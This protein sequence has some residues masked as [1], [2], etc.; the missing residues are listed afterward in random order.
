MSIRLKIILG[1]LVILLISCKD[2]V[3]QETVKIGIIAPLSDWGAYWGIPFINGAEIAKEDVNNN[4]VKLEIIPEDSKGNGK[5]A[6]TAVQ[7]LIN[8]DEITAAIVEFA[9][10]TLAVSPLLKE[11]E[12]PFIYDAFVKSPLL[13]NEYAFKS[14]IDVAEGCR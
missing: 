7:K 4:Q 13:A 1:I 14:F 10:P 3:K 12:I 2:V 11:A 9:P 6:I 5:D 8:V